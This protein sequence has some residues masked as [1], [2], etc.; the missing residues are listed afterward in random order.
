MPSLLFLL[1]TSRLHG[2]RGQAKTVLSEG[3]ISNDTS[4]EEKQFT[5]GQVGR[6]GA[7]ISGKMS[8][9]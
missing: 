4:T 1:E 5:A 3:G 9:H 6:G 2:S 7:R 8:M